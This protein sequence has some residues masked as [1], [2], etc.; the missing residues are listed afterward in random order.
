M[1]KILALMLAGIL[2]FGLF[3]CG[4][5]NAGQNN[6]SDQEPASGQVESQPETPKEITLEDVN[7]FL[8]ESGDLGPGSTANSVSVIPFK[9]VDG[10]DI[11]SDFYAFVNFQY[12]ESDYVKYQ[13]SFIS[14]T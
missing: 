7:K 9:H 14:C 11:D 10:G 2:I 12:A 8:N 13:V 3:G 4:S 1:K 5:D 6:D